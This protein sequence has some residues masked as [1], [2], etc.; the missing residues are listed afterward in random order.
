MDLCIAG[1]PIC[2]ESAD[3]AYFAQRFADYVRH[4]DREPMMVMRTRRMKHIPL[5]TGEPVQQINRMC[6]IRLPDGRLCRYICG[7][8]PDGRTGPVLLSIIYTPDY[9][10]VDIALYDLLQHPDFTITDFEYMYTGEA[11][12]NRV[13]Y[14]G[15]GVLHSSSLAWNGQGVAFSATS[16]TGKSTHVGLWKEYFGDA[17]EIINDDK[18]VILFEGEQAMLC[19]TP[20]SGKT[21]LNCN[22]AVPLK[23]IVFIERGDKNTIR[24][25]DTV[26]SMFQLISQMKRSFY[27]EALSISTLGFAERLLENVPI[28]GLSCDIS[29][30]AV[31]TVFH[32]IF[33]QEVVR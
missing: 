2:V 14:L 25:L 27:D 31:E 30:E 5:P 21:A 20:W 8:Y 15:G 28:Y 17:V 6:T 18:P 19:G 33:P 9:A 13:A 1:L 24:R 16:G 29:R 7:Q 4:D 3:E 32:E 11:F 26:D 12:G 23:A 10:Q 22:R